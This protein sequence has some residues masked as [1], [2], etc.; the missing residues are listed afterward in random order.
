MA[1]YFLLLFSWVAA[2]LK[3]IQGKNQAKGI[4]LNLKKVFRPGQELPS[5]Y[6]PRFIDLIN[7]IGLLF[8]YLGP[9]GLDP[10]L[11]IYCL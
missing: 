8:I 9:A 4:D 2:G 7:L 6:W 10:N 5:Q 1:I 3:G 11:P